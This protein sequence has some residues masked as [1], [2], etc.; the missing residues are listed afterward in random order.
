MNWIE[1]EM[2]GQE[3]DKRILQVTRE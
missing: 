3:L 2:E 1:G